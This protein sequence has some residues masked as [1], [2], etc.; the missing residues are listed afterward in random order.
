MNDKAP[1][2]LLAALVDDLV[3]WWHTYAY[4]DRA[5]WEVTGEHLPVGIRDAALVYIEHVVHQITRHVR[6][7]Q[8]AAWRRLYDTLPES[9]ADDWRKPQLDPREVMVTH[10]RSGAPPQVK[11]SYSLF[12]EPTGVRVAAAVDRQASEGPHLSSE[13]LFEQAMRK[14]AKDVASFRSAAVTFPHADEVTFKRRVDVEDGV[15]RVPRWTLTH[16]PTGVTVDCQPPTPGESAREALTRAHK[17]L[18]EKVAAHV[19][20]AAA[21]GPLG[22]ESARLL[23]EHG[24]LP[25]G[26][27]SERHQPGLPSFPEIGRDRLDPDGICRCPQHPDA[28]GDL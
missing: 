13:E 23:L 17:H 26:V 19:R 24:G 27:I 16:R 7:E 3:S 9:H 15:L 12:H 2:P 4:L 21:T 6:L 18:G 1:A 5:P 25:P 22:P 20:S 28:P 8:E 11:E 10:S 14:L